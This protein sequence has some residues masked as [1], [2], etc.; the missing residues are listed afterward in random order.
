[1][2]FEIELDCDKFWNMP[3]P[4][5]KIFQGLMVNWLQMIPGDMWHSPYSRVFQFKKAEDA[6]AFKLKFGL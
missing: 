2:E 5:W 4:E 1:M 3:L 6:L